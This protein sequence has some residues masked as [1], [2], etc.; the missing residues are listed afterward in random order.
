[1]ADIAQWT[2]FPGQEIRYRSDVRV[3]QATHSSIALTLE[4][5]TRLTGESQWPSFLKDHSYYANGSCV[6]AL[7]GI[8]VSLQSRWEY[9]AAPGASDSYFT[10]YLGTRALVEL[11][12]GPQEHFIPEIYVTPAEGQA[13]YEAKLKAAVSRLQ[14]HYPGLSYEIAGHSFHLLLP[15][16]AREADSLRTIFQE[17][18]GFVRDPATFPHSENSNL[19]AKYYVTTTAVAMANAKH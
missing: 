8:H 10:S 18:A 5:F 17:F 16:A 4:Q 15:K 1:L 7:K 13:N 14:T 3:W 11:R 2:L 12:A 6:Y 9:E 19:L